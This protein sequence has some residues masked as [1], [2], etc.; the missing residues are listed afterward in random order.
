MR[1]KQRKREENDM[2]HTR[3][4]LSW[5]LAAL[6]LFGC[7]S[8]FGCS[9]A[10][11]KT[12]MDIDEVEEALDDEGY[13]VE[14]FSSSELVEGYESGLVA[15]D[16][17]IKVEFYELEKRSNAKALLE[18]VYENVDDDSGV[19]SNVDVT[20]PNYTVTRFSDGDGTYYIISQVEKTVLIVYGD[21]DYKD[22]IKNLAS[23]LGYN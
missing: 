17:D 23:D 18:A 15:D 1:L 16:G 2:K 19:T 7:A 14:R 22:D 21:K 20:G 4:V 10:K 8:L 5:L 12:P 6:M 9:I 13:D 3:K 11:E